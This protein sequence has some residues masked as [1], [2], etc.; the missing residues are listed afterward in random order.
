[1][2]KEEQMSIFPGCPSISR[3]KGG[4]SRGGGGGGQLGDWTM[5]FTLR[6][7]TMPF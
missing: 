6:R 3:V 2:P 7:L 4:Q 1:M 5:V